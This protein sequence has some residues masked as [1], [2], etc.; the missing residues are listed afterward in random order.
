MLL[1]E[2]QTERE[3]VL[4]V[5][6]AVLEAALAKEEQESKRLRAK[7]AEQGERLQ[8]VCSK[9]QVEQNAHASDVKTLRY[10]N[11][12]LV[13]EHA[14]RCKQLEQ[15]VACGEKVSAL[16]AAAEVLRV[17]NSALAQQVNELKGAVTGPTHYEVLHGMA[18]CMNGMGDDE[19]VLLLLLAI[20][21]VGDQIC[22]GCVVSAACRSAGGQMLGGE[23]AGAAGGD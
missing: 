10:R 22:A 4:G 2:A 5:R 21:R 12:I 6:I 17:Q 14:A 11:E 8:V 15:Q 18:L 3:R 16:E 23:W 20:L 13:M 1:P 9:L 7:T 19:Q